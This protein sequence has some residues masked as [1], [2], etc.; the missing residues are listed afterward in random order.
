MFIVGDTCFA[1]W[2]GK[3]KLYQCKIIG[4][5][6]KTFS[7]VYAD[8]DKDPAVPKELCKDSPGAGAA[9]AQTPQLTAEQVQALWVAELAMTPEERRR[10]YKVGARFVEAK[11]LPMWNNYGRVIPPKESKHA[12]RPDLNSKI[13]LWRGNICALEIS[14]I[15][16]AANERCLGG[17]GIDGA[18]HSAAGRA[19]YEECRTL[20]GCPTGET[21]ITLGYNLPAQYVLH[22]VGPIGENPEALTSCYRSILDLCKAKGV[23][24]V[25]MCGIST[26]IF[27]YPLVNAATVALSTTRTWLETGDNAE[28][29]DQVVFVNFKAEEEQVYEFLTPQFF[30]LPPEDLAPEDQRKSVPEYRAPPKRAFGFGGFGGFG[31]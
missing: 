16:N 15:V 14:S 20:N 28:S 25:A 12:V 10:R 4:T 24:S 6:G 21:K 26:G 13:T 8:G 30:P 3:G 9:Y 31:R 23:R 11:S 2:K 5:D 29:I 22:S 7:L 18:I 19:L 17:G 27:D 1:P